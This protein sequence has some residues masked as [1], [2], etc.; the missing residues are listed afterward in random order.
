MAVL[1]GEQLGRGEANPG[2]GYLIGWRGCFV[3]RVVLTLPPCAIV[4]EVWVDE[5]SA[6]VHIELLHLAN[7]YRE[8]AW[9]LSRTASS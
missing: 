5:Q 1:D 8:V 6:D 4:T 9:R 2:L 3:G 7:P